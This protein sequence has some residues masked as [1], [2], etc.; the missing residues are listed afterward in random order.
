VYCTGT[1]ISPTA[2][3]SARHCLPTGALRSVVYFEVMNPDNWQAAR[4]FRGWAV[5]PAQQLSDGIR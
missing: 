1:L 3:L 4:T 5:H 2:V